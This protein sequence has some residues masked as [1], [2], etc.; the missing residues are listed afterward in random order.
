MKRNFTYRSTDGHTRIHAIEWVPEGEVRGVLQLIH[1][2]VEYIGRYDRFA[3][4]MASHGWY[5]VGN[6]HLGHGASVISEKYYGYF[7]EPDGNRNVIMD[8]RKLQKH[9]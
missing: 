8:I 5:V 6:D 2:M 7:G 3:R 1:G 4:F 9:T